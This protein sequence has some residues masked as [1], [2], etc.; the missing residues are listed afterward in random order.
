MF[1]SGR[2]PVA[3]QGK[4]TPLSAM[5]VSS[6]GLPRHAFPPTCSSVSCPVRESVQLPWDEGR[7]TV[8]EA[9]W[10]WSEVEVVNVGAPEEVRSEAAS[11]ITPVLP[12][13]S[14]LA[15]EETPAFLGTGM[16]AAAAVA[17]FFSSISSLRNRC[18]RWSSVFG[19]L[20]PQLRSWWCF[21]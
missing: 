20:N 13:T 9:C 19:A 1:V 11:L 8:E 5:S 2:C 21:F 16:A 6:C 3:R 10:F 17:A 7:V 15:L 14:H 12:A 18:T 4:L